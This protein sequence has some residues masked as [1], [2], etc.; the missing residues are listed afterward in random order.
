VKPA[1]FGRWQGYCR[2]LEL[3]A[4]AVDAVADALRRCP[5]GEDRDFL[6]AQ[7]EALNGVRARLEAWCREAAPP[8]PAPPASNNS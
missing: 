5:A 7:H 3:I 2:A 1:A 4:P 8:A 6:A